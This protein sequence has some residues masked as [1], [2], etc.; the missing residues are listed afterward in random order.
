MSDPAKEY[1]GVFE[2]LQTGAIEELELAAKVVEY[3]PCGRAPYLGEAWAGHAIGLASLS[4]LRW[5]SDDGV[6]FDYSSDAEDPA[7]L[8]AIERS[9]AGKYSVLKFLI[10]EGCDLNIRDYR[11]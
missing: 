10:D 3:L 4:T 1:L 8:S 9:D 6:D 2:I 7:D 5:M 11:R